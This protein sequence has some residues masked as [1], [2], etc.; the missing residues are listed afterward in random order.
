MRSRAKSGEET[1]SNLRSNH[2]GKKDYMRSPQKPHSLSII[3]PPEH[4][5]QIKKLMY[6]TWSSPIE[7][8]YKLGYVKRGST[9]FKV[10]KD[11]CGVPSAA[12]ALLVPEGLLM[13]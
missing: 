9:A 7:T 4:R 3:L 13:Q 6:R 5:R 11:G 10:Q 2:L 12:R 1:Q 8:I